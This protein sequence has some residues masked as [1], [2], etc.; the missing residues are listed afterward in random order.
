MRLS[1]VAVI[2][3]AVAMVGCKGNSAA[4]AGNREVCQRAVDR[5]NECVKLDDDARKRMQSNVE[6]C[7]GREEAVFQK[8]LAT[9]SCPEFT[10]CLLTNAAND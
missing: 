6:H 8:C 5:Y 1:R 10:T 2:I 7:T 4:P 3:A 9:T